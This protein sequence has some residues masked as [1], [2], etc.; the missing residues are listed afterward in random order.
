MNEGKS[1]KREARK[2][3]KKF[4]WVLKAEG[5]G[6]LLLSHLLV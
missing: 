2:Q 5:K 1:G 6:K 3:R 4:F